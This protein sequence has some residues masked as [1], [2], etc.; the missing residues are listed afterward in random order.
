[1]TAP[2]SAGHRT[3][4]QLVEAILGGER[5]AYRHLVER[6]EDPLFRRAVS[7]VRDPELA[8]DMVQET[9]VR[10][11]ERLADC[12]DPDRFGGWVYRTLR[13]RCYDELR[14]ARRRA[15][16]LTAASAVAGDEDP[17]EDLER[18]EL[19]RMIEAALGTLSPVLREAFVL[20]HVDGLSYDEM[21]ET[22]GVAR[23]ALKMRV[24][25]AREELEGILRPRVQPPG[26]VT[27]DR[28]ESSMGWEDARPTHWGQL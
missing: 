5:A 2:G 26:D 19:R 8:A 27:R 1:M 22:T 24:K 11:Y 6:H 12:S 25:R 18:V 23:S 10:A 16:P 28:P 14:A 7:I 4:R 15:Q 21:Q 20:K 3:D 13:N 9:F 17:S